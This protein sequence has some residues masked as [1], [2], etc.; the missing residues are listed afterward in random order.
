MSG[1][2]LIRCVFGMT[3]IS[4]VTPACSCPAKETILRGRFLVVVEDGYTHTRIC[5]AT[6]S[7]RA[8]DSGPTST[9]AH[10]TFEYGGKCAYEAEDVEVAPGYAHVCVRAAGYMPLQVQVAVPLRKTDERCPEPYV[11]PTSLL[12][13]VEPDLNRPDAGPADAGAG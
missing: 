13:E 9:V 12:A 3:V 7:I 6:V 1:W 10:Q 11:A 8:P 5:N 4:G 2:R